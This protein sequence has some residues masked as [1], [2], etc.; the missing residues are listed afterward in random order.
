MMEE[1]T[2]KLLGP[3]FLPTEPGHKYVAKTGATE[4]KI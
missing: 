1:A 2:T 3:T 4:D